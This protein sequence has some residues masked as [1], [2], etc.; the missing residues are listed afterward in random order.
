[1]A[2]QADEAKNRAARRRESTARSNR[3]APS[4]TRGNAANLPLCPWGTRK[5]ARRSASS[6]SATPMARQ[7]GKGATRCAGG[8]APT[9]SWRRRGISCR[10]NSIALPVFT[11]Q[12][13]ASAPS[14]RS[15]TGRRKAARVI[16]ATRTAPA[17]STACTKAPCVK[18]SPPAAAGSAG[19]GS[20]RPRAAGMPTEE[21]RQRNTRRRS[22]RRAIRTADATCTAQA[23]TEATP[24]AT[25]STRAASVRRQ[26]RAERQSSQV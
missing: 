12:S 17:A 24:T 8:K 23:A 18:S 26:A 2:M 3:H 16:W 11:W 21:W 14:P 20:G 7:A 19:P 10:T 9:N 25:T 22:A 13:L 15:T 4:A 1:M 6:N 5:N